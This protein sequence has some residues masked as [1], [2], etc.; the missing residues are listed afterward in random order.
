MTS[1]LDIYRSANVLIREHGEDAALDQPYRSGITGLT[2]IYLQSRHLLRNHVPSFSSLHP[3]KWFEPAR[4]FVLCRWQKNQW[5]GPS[6][7]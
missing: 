6:F 5:S 7:R 1:D 2:V 3:G 4:H